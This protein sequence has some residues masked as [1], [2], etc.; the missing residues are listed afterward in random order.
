V[1][2]GIH[3]GVNLLAA[4]AVKTA[5]DIVDMKRFL[6]SQEAH[7]IK[8]Y[9]RLHRPEAYDQI[10]AIIHAADGILIGSGDIAWMG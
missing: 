10:D 6:D 3:S 4:S 8:V 1:I 5:D 9:A 2:R 7:G